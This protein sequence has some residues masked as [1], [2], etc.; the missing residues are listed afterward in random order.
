MR[1]DRRIADAGL[2]VS[3]YPVG[4]RGVHGADVSHRPA[5]RVLR[6]EVWR[7]H[8]SAHAR[9]GLR[10]LGLDG[11]LA[12]LCLIHVSAVLDRG[13]DLVGGIGTAVWH[14]PR[15][16]THFEL[17]GRHSDRDLRDRNDQPDANRHPA[18]LGHAAIRADHLHRV[19]ESGGLLRLD[20]L[21]RL[22]GRQWRAC[23]P[24]DARHG[25]F[26]AA[27]SPAADRRASRL[28]AVS[29]RPQWPRSLQLVDRSPRHGPGMGSDRRIQVVD[30]LIL[31]GARAALR[32]SD[33][34]GQRTDSHVPGGV[35]GGLCVSHLRAVTDGHLR[36]RLPAQDQRDQ[37]LCRL[38]RVVEFFLAPHPQPPR[39]RRLVGIQRRVGPRPHGMRHFSCD[40]RDPEDLR[41]F[42]GRLDRRAHRGPGDQQIDRLEPPSYRV[43]AGLSVRCQS[44]RGR[45]FAAIRRGL[46][47]G[48]PRRVRPL[49]A[50]T[51]AFR[52]PADRVRRGAADCMDDPRPVLPRP[53]GGNIPA[54]C[55]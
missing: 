47:G 33:D 1:G 10:L 54:Q 26:H 6:R 41:Q 18:Y 46:D 28:S 22:P 44:R 52:G 31:G 3:E 40:R 21:W 55:R 12:D 17:A 13:D 8:R 38:D 27:V 36:H 15:G 23:Q 48:S 37:C 35:S 53:P 45:R 24:A 20:P 11:D 4:H 50:D 51:L 16:R 9:R 39:P 34:G 2:R 14:S 5:D 43:S 32:C 30:G 42:C 19:E 29:A 7:R 25:S 49:C